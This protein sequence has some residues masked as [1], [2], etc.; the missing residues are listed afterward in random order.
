M[1]SGYERPKGEREIATVDSLIWR[2]HDATL[3]AV[4]G[5]VCVVTGASSGVGKEV[6]IGLARAG[7]RVVMICRDRTRGENAASD[8]A[9]HGPAPELRLAELG[10]QRDVRRVAEE[11]RSSHDRIDALVHNAGAVHPARR[12]TGDGIETTLAVNHLA[13]FLLTQLLLDTLKNSAPARIVVV[14]SQV[15]KRGAIDFDDLQSERS[16]EPLKAYFQSKL[17]NVLFTY[18]LARRLQDTSVTVNCL[19]PGVIA[20]NLLATYMGKASLGL[21]DRLL[22]PAPAAAAKMIVRLALDP[23]FS[24]TTGAYF[25]ETRRAESSATSH[26]RALQKRLWDVSEA[27]VSSPPR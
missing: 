11:V 12:V 18:E 21:R 2:H 6:S 17:A 4:K 10:E 22:N 26:D 27:L 19:H 8:V 14:A 3:A 16:Y 5:S 23:A 25:H 7:A 13:P 24:S 20:T 9:R 15:E 1:S